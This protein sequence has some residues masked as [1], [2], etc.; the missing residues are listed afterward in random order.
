MNQAED[1]FMGVTQGPKHN[2]LYVVVHDGKGCFRV[3]M[4]HS[5]P[6]M[7]YFCLYFRN[8]ALNKK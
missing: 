2:P 7:K 8:A 3:L 1:V 4:L 6:L 5:L